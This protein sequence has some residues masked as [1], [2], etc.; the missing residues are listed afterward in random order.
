MNVTLVN[1]STWSDESLQAIL[2][3]LAP[4]FGHV[5]KPVR[6]TVRSK[7]GVGTWGKAYWPVEKDIRHVIKPGEYAVIVNIGASRC[8]YPV[9]RVYKKRAGGY[10]AENL[11]ECFVHTLAHELRHVEQF[12]ACALQREERRLAGKM[13]GIGMPFWTYFRMR[14]RHDFQHSSNSCEVDAERLA[15]GLLDAYRTYISLKEVA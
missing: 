14:E 6:L 4:C 13:W 1:K 2:D 9:H 8:E 5:S 15:H 12:E 7:R 11:V 3:F 10:T